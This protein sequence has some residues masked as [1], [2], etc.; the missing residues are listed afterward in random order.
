M[1]NWAWA[2]SGWREFIA[3]DSRKKILQRRDLLL[4]P[5]RTHEC[6]GHGQSERTISP[7]HPDSSTVI[8]TLSDDS[9][10]R[11]LNTHDDHKFESDMQGNCV[12]DHAFDGNVHS[13]RD[14]NN[15]IG[16]AH[17]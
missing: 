11:K 3:A 15:E 16:R 7:G 8:H 4:D 13:L 14:K 9:T 12:R 10:I 6:G 2:N 5:D 1:R 17:V